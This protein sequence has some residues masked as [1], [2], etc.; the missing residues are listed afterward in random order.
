[1]LS[2]SKVKYLFCFLVIIY[3]L[4]F[5]LSFYVPISVSQHP[6]QLYAVNGRLL[7][8]WFRNVAFTPS[9]FQA[10]PEFIFESRSG[11]YSLAT[12]ILVVVSF[13]INL[14]FPLVFPCLFFVRRRW[15]NRPVNPA[16]CT[17]CGY[18]LSASGVVQCSECGVKRSPASSK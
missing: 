15:A 1:M 6:F 2:M 10:F 14:M 18:D 13:W 5:I 7:I 12:G 16:L 4:L 11:V 3:Y 17:N 8:A 9:V